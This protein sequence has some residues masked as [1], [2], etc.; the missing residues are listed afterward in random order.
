MLSIK[1][2][3]AAIVFTDGNEVV[4]ED[5]FGTCIDGDKAGVRD[6]EIIQKAIDAASPAGEI[7][8]CKG[9]YKLEK[10]LVITSNLLFHGEGRGTIFRPPQDDYAI[11]VETTD[12]TDIP[13]PYQGSWK[14]TKHLYA[15]VV[16]E[17][18][19]DG[20]IDGDPETGKGI[21]MRDFWSS[22]FENIWI[23]K[24]GNALY[25]RN[26][27][28][29]AFRNLFLLRNG[30]VNTDEPSVL[31][32]EQ[33]DNNHVTKMTLIYP[34]HTGVYLKG[35]QGDPSQSPRLL[36]F[37]DCMLHGWNVTEDGPAQCPLIRMEHVDKQRTDVTFNNC[38][39]TVAAKGQASFDLD[40]AAVSVRNSVISA[41]FGKY[42][43]KAKKN[44]RIRSVGNTFHS[45][46]PETNDYVVHAEHSQV[47][48]KDNVLIGR[49]LGVKLI[50][51]RDSVITHNTF[52]I[53]T[54]KITID[55][56]D[57]GDQGSE[58][59]VVQQNTCRELSAEAALHVAEQSAASTIVD[60]NYFAGNYAKQ[61]SLA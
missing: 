48:F 58:N 1:W 40:N 52:E 34:R 19:I 44:S 17:F 60:G 21:Y 28:E 30:N 49:N 46:D 31:F 29:S 61:A 5:R 7:K 24:T 41:T 37:N 13:R 3:C 11:K 38:R 18:C 42:I 23:E 50:A 43:F 54:G 25:L 47:L 2:D 26:V 39:I 12:A 16:K 4:A 20:G 51:A 32:D 59:I 45:G 8:I 15:V 10:S 33:S 56:E 6:A 36:W 14:G 27:H 22:S 9:V 55:I 57:D 35:K 53:E